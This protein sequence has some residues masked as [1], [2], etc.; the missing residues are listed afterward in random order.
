MSVIYIFSVLDTLLFMQ[1][2]LY[3]NIPD[4]III[5]VQNTCILAYPTYC[6]KHD[7]AFQV[8]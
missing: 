7:S 4:R 2:T 8:V 6:G 3:V 1:L 5:C